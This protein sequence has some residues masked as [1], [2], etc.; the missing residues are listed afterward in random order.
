MTRRASLLTAEMEA[1]LHEQR[2]RVADL[3]SLIQCVQC[4]GEDQTE[5]P[6]RIDDF[7]SAMRGLITLADQISEALDPEQFEKTLRVLSQEK[8]GVP[9]SP[10]D[11]SASPAR[12]HV[13]V[14]NTAKR[15]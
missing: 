6:G 13:I 3:R 7:Y 4:A 12:P 1:L 5:G 9:P 2:D 14:D 15:P 11:P 8:P 10:P